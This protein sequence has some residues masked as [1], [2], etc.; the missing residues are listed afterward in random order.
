MHSAW[1]ED[2]HRVSKPRSMQSQ[3]CSQSK[4]LCFCT[5]RSKTCVIWIAILCMTHGPYAAYSFTAYPTTNSHPIS[6]GLIASSRIV[7]LPRRGMVT[8]IQHRTKQHIAYSSTRASTTIYAEILSETL[9][10]EEEWEPP[11]EGEYCSLDHHAEGEEKNQYFINS[12][13]VTSSKETFNPIMI[14][15]IMTPFLAYMTY[16]DV[17]RTFSAIFDLLARDRKW[18]PVDGGAY[19]AKIIAPAINGIVVPAIS[20]L[21]ATL[22]SNTVSTLRQRQID[23]HT[24]LNSE[25]GDLRVLSMLVDAYPKSEQKARCRE[26]L[27]QYTCRLIAESEDSKTSKVM[28]GS[29]DSEMNGFVA[30]LNEL[31]VNRNGAISPPD[32]VLSQSY[33]AVVRL[34][35][36]RSSRITALQSTYPSLHYGILSLLASSIC[37][38]FLLETNQDIL[39][40][41]NAIQLRILWTMLIGSIS[42]LS[43]VCWDLSFPFTGSYVIS[44]AVDQLKTIRDTIRAVTDTEEEEDEE[45]E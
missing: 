36:I 30:T 23:I 4:M 44:N 42:A 9:D 3:S 26:Y 17:A 1:I 5:I 43:V 19:Q 8:I 25:A 20:I 10:K 24:N 45:D 21:F 38:A 6:S 41:L 22:T 33:G 31:A 7:K 16:D 13:P 34:N 39:I 18:I 37:L 40:F 15:P 32:V 29:T 27:N 12:Q 14:I 28:F 11:C 2:K 35:T